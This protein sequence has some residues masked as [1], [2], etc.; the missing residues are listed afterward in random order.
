[1]IMLQILDSLKS[2][3]SPELLA[4]A[5]A[6]L[7]ED[8]SKVTSAVTSMVP[9]MLGS[10]MNTGNTSEVRSVLED[11]GKSNLLSDLTNLFS[12]NASEKQRSIGSRFMDAIMG[13]HVS[14]FNSLIASHSGI[15]TGSANK[16]T[17]MI[18]P[19]IAGFLGNK[20]N[21]GEYNVSGLMNQLEREKSSI[22]GMIPAGFTSVLGLKSL[23]DIGRDHT[24][25]EEKIRPTAATGVAETHKGGY[26]WLKWLL[27]VLLLLLL[28]FWWRS[29]RGHRHEGMEQPRIER[30]DTVT[31]RPSEAVATTERR[32]STELVLPNNVKLSGYRN[33]MEDQMI[34]YLKSDKYE[35]ATD[36]DLQFKWYD[37]D[38]M[39]FKFG[40]A[41][42]LTES[43]NAQLENIAA[44][45]KYYDDVKVK[46][47]GY[48]D[49]VGDDESNMK[50]SEARAQTI[51]S[52][53]EQKGIAANRISTE[54]FGEELAKYSASAP[55]SDRIHDRQV[56][57]R[58]MK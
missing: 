7:G 14:D 12:G 58:F 22:I 9:S 44:I 50:L 5:S 55:E 29:C 23:S 11:A 8:N 32:T 18:A 52:M 35:D 54:G 28:F 36:K 51:K 45:L 4:K 47:G 10:L 1:M 38:N 15:T 33:G 20:L 3:I 56:A 53:L 43:S 2:L 6:V 27:L 40:S 21:M 37:F 24:Y 34:D 17:N 48:A 39:A 19:V 49:K 25:R 26:G 31:P 13:G 42:E 41:T 57:L 46:I 16:L 30:V